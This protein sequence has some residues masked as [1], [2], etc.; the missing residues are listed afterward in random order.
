LLPGRAGP[1]ADNS[2]RR[3]ES[4]SSPNRSRYTSGRSTGGT[5][6][7]GT[8]STLTGTSRSPAAPGTR[9][10][11]ADHST[12]VYRSR[13]KYAAENNATTRSAR[14]SASLIAVAK[15]RPAGQSNTSSSTLKPALINCQATHSAHTASWPAWLLK[16]STRSPS[17]PQVSSR[18]AIS[19]SASFPSAVA[20]VPPL[21]TV[22]RLFAL[23]VG[24]GHERV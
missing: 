8:S 18:S 1:M 22:A 23:T 17:T 20:R 10:S 13:P 7:A 3:A 9:A 5:R 15:F 16:K 14:S 24:S 21:R 19:G 12:V 4:S 2:A 6:W 11:D